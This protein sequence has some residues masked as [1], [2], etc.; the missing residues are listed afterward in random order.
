ML[1][2]RD[3]SLSILRGEKLGL[4]GESGCG[5]STLGRM[6]AGILPPSEGGVTLDGAPVMA[7]GRKATTRIQ[8][9]FQDP[10]AS[11][12]PR[13][14][15][16]DTIAEGPAAHRRI[17]R[18]ERAAFARRWLEKVGLPAECATRY[19][20]QF[21]GGQRQ[22]IAIARAL[23][24]EPDL[25]VCDE[26]IAS[27]DVSVQAQILN[28]FLALGGDAGLTMLFISHDLAAVRHL[29]DRIA[30]MYLGRIVEI[31]VAGQVYDAP[32]HP[33]TAALIDAI[34]KLQAAASVFRPIAGE[35]PSPSR[36]PTGCAFHPRCG[37]A[38]GGAARRCRCCGRSC[39]DSSAP[40]IVPR[41]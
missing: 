36:P 12:D 25:L 32:R 28:L 23:A 41:R 22:R 7:G 11:L 27:L 35:V 24:M 40:V 16:G 14:A 4:V 34:P 2:V 13:M 19:P 38:V 29:C 30:V 33:Y 31:G 21:S 17:R 10:F 20:H 9:V 5:K 37:L 26:P 15:A 18:S 8:T 39:R 3:V 1:A 6:I